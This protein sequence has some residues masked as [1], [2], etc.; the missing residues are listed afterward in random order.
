MMV[1]PKKSWLLFALKLQTVNSRLEAEQLSFLSDDHGVCNGD[2]GD[3]GNDDVDVGNDENDNN[4]KLDLGTPINSI[5][6]FFG[7]FCSVIFSLKRSLQTDDN[8]GSDGNEG[9]Q[10]QR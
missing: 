2:N 5:Q 10:W 1:L 6:L 9:D 3:S 8:D 4:G 7:R